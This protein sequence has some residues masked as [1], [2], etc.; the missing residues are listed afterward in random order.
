MAHVFW[1]LADLISYAVALS[2]LMIKI[3]HAMEL[4]DILV[5]AIL[6][7]VIFVALKWQVMILPAL[8]IFE[9]ME[10]VTSDGRRYRLYEQISDNEQPGVQFAKSIIDDNTIGEAKSMKDLNQDPPSTS[11]QGS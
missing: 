1:F 10:Y 8:R 2:L 5:P 6:L 4:K 7:A 9:N 11:P 3:T